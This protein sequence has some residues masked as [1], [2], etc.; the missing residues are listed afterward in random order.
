MKMQKYTSILISDFNINIFSGFLNNDRGLPS[1]ETTVAPFGQVM[2]V[3]MQSHLEC[4]RGKF[5]FAVVWAQP[6]R[7]IESFNHTLN[8]KNVSIEEVGNA[9]AFLCS[10]LASGITGEITYV[11]GGYNIAGLAAG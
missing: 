11:D 9:A 3:L 5:D 8:Y 6:E 2:P 7:V 10:D 1:V 4:W